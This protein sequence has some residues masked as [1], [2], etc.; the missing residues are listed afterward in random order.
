MQGVMT[1]CDYFVLCHSRSKAHSQALAE[2]VEEKLDEREI[3]PLHREGVKDATWVILDYMHVVVHIFSEE[4]RE[5]YDLR[6]LWGEAPEV[7]VEGIEP[8]PRETE[9][10]PHEPLT[11]SAADELELAD[12]LDEEPEDE[13]EA[14]DDLEDEP[15]D[16]SAPE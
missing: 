1:I 9:F 7:E 2:Y 3:F 8:E 14:E 15:E 4:A 6:R 13:L 12:D 11:A 5:F 16:E 10:S